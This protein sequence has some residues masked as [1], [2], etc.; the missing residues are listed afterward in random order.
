CQIYLPSGAI[1]GLDGVKSASLGRIDKVTLTTRKPPRSLEGAPYL[2]S[3][4]I[5]LSQIKQETLLFEGTAEEAIRGFPQNVNVCATLSIA[6]IGP[7]KTRVKIIT[8]PFYTSNIHEVEAEGAFG[9]LTVRTENVPSPQNPKTS[10]LA[11]LSA[12]ATLKQI[13]EPVKIG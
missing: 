13:L 9:R 1:C 6:G 11:A 3:K 10:Y 7:E 12:I 4:G 5:N 8:S 2:V